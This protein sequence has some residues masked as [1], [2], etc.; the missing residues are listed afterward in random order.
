MVVKVGVVLELEGQKRKERGLVWRQIKEE[1]E[2]LVSRL[3]KLCFRFGVVWVLIKLR[4]I[5]ILDREWFGS[6]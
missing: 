6:L 4:I 5:E 1:I 3:Q 2:G